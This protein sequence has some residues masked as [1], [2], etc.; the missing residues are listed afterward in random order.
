MISHAGAGTCIEV[1]QTGKTLAVI[2]N[3]SLMDNHQVELAEKLAEVKQNINQ[4]TYWQYCIKG[5]ISCLWH[6]LDSGWN[7]RKFK[8]YKVKAI[9]K[10]EL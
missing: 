8:K 5:R 7:N 6:R 3:D 10:T 2:V 1:L 4:M 9:S